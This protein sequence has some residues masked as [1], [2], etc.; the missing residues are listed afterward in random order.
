ML[1]SSAPTMPRW[2]FAHREPYVRVKFSEIPLGRITRTWGL[3][4]IDMA[5]CNAIRSNRG[6]AYY[7][8]FD[9]H[10]IA[11]RKHG[12]RRGLLEF[13]LKRCARARRYVER[14]FEHL[15]QSSTSGRPISETSTG[16]TQFA[17]CTLT[18]FF[19]PHPPL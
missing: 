12:G 4:A 5:V 15:R 6:T 7:T 9:I 16:R 1:N 11:L 17:S 19:R 3:K 18:H 8:W 2:I 13:C 10:R 14:T